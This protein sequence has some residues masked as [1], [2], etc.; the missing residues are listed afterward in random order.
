[1]SA[2]K[3]AGGECDETCLLARVTSLHIVETE[4]SK[5]EEE[6]DP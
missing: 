4:T 6:K 5:K 3:K 2:N 1:M